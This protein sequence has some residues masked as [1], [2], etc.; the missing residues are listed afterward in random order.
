MIYPVRVYN[1]E[2]VLIREYSVKELIEKSLEKIQSNIPFVNIS[3]VFEQT[4][5]S[6]DMFPTK[7]KNMR[8]LNDRIISDD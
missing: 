5:D 2:G 8:F 1:K 6:Y 7:S 3:G 4:I